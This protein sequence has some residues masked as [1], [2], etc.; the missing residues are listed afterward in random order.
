VPSSRSASKSRAFLDLEAESALGVQSF[1]CKKPRAF[2]RKEF[3]LNFDYVDFVPARFVC[4]ISR[5]KRRRP[6]FVEHCQ[7]AAVVGAAVVRDP[8][9]GRYPNI[10]H[11]NG[12]L[13][14]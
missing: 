6:F 4:G 1:T 8:I 2:R 10:L 7:Q 11:L 12:V 9:F 5:Q 13:L 14:P 3:Q